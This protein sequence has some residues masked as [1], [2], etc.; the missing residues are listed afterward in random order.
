MDSNEEEILSAAMNLR[1]ISIDWKITAEESSP[2]CEDEEDGEEEFEFSFA[3]PSPGA[4]EKIE[5]IS[6]DEIFANGQIRAAYCVPE[7]EISAPADE[8]EGVSAESYC[9]WSPLEMRR[10]CHSTGESRRWRLRD[11]VIGRSLSDGKKKFVFLDLSQSEEKSKEK[12]SMKKKEKEKKKSVSSLKPE[13]DMVTAHRLFYS[14]G[15]ASSADRRRSYLP[16]RNHL[17]GFFA[18]SSSHHSF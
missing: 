8:L 6:A 1:R 18:N 12:E 16:Y 3:V 14:K 11:L 5:S 15:G 9:L 10:R 17:F 2:N 13:M 4:L 7:K